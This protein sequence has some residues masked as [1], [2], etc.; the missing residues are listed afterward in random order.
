LSLVTAGSLSSP[1]TALYPQT[2]TKCLP[3]LGKKTSFGGAAPNEYVRPG[4]DIAPT[5]AAIK[6]YVDPQFLTIKT[7][8]LIEQGLADT[9]VLPSLTEITVGD[10]RKRGIKLTYHTYKGLDHGGVTTAKAPQADA[11][12]Y[13]A[14][15]LK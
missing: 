4:A 5:L 6:K 9:T 2:L 3:D 1:A 8:L 14:A 7:P 12:A 15:R 11:T 10:Y 13:I